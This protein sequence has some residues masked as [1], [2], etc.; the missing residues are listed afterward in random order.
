MVKALVS[1]NAEK[2]LLTLEQFHELAAVPP[3]I[4]WLAN[5][6]NPNTK[7]AYRRDVAGFMRFVGIRAPD[8]LRLVTRAHVIA[9]RDSLKRFSPATV[10]R[11]LS[12]LSSLLNYL[13]DQNALESCVADGVMRPIENSN[14]GKTPALSD[15]QARR[16]LEEP[17]SDTVKGK[18]DRAILSVMLFHGLRRSELCALRIKDVSERRGVVMLTVRGKRG[19][20]RYLPLN[21]HSASVV[22]DY[23][24]VAG[25]RNDSEGA[26]F[27]PLTGPREACRRG[28]SPGAIFR[29]IVLKYGRALGITAEGFGPHSLRTTAATNALEHAAELADVRDWLGHSNVSTTTLYDRRKMQPEKSPTFRVKY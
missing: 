10:R 3:E 23:L 26:L 1:S 6:E 19:K 14:E 8:E 22:A 27:R 13:C 4:E 9:W 2:R 17:P 18:R 25:H 15:V 16:L 12:A 29:C 28:L 11:K 21:P 20:I 24:Q 7:D 5:I